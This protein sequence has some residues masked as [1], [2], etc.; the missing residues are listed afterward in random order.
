MKAAIYVRKSTDQRDRDDVEKSVAP[1]SSTVREASA[2]KKCPDCAEDI[3]DAAIYCKHCGRDMPPPKSAVWFDTGQQRRSQ[4][5]RSPQ[6][7]RLEW[8]AP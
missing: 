7:G 5:R 4:R 2:M 1:T 8:G 6:A 3:Q